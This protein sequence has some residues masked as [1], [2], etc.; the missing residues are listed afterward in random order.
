M[1]HLYRPLR[2]LLLRRAVLV[3]V[4]AGVLL[5]NG[6]LLRPSN[7]VAVPQLLTP[8]VEADTSRLIE[9]INRLSTVRSIRGKVDIQFLDTSFAKCGVAEKYKT[10]DGTLTVQRPRQINL[11][12]QIPFIGR[13]VAQMTSDGERFRVAVLEGDE[14]FKRFVKGTNNAVYPKLETDGAEVDC[15]GD[16]KKRSAMNARAVGALSSLR[17]QHFTDALLIYPAAEPGSN[18]VYAQSEAF[19]EE[20]DAR[21]GAKKNARVV[22]AYYVLAE[23]QP[24]GENRARIVRRFWFDRVGEIRLARLQNYDEQGKLTT[25]VVYKETRT[26]G[27]EARYKLPSQIELTRPQDRYSIRL[28]YQAPDSVKI[29]QPYKTDFFDLKNSW[30]LPEVD[31]DARK[32]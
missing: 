32:P 17:P 3:L 21:T 24:T 12:I 6:C 29:D 16:D 28:S 9:E 31:L 10:A 5:T 26:L 30:N 22:R 20:P 1:L 13:D 23:L 25:D 18:L 8:V 19:E 27:E 2:V 14:R 4:V 11:V 15:G 7:K